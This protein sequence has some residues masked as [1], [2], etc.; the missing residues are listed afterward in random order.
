MIPEMDGFEFLARIGEDERW[1]ALP[2]V[3]M[4]AKTLTASDRERLSG[5]VEQLVE[6]SSYNL[7]SLLGDLDAV[8][9]RS[10]GPQSG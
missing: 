4:T 10:A 1:R 3:V 7:D 9:R 2:V 8:L 5:R 6:K